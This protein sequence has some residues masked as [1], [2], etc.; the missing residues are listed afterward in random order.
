MADTILDGDFTIFYDEDSN[1]KQLKWTGA[2]AGFRT[3]NELY[4]ALFK[5]F[6][7]P[8]QMEDAMP[9]R[10]DTPTVYR[11]INAYFIDDVTVEHLRGGSIYSSG[12]KSGTTEHVLVIGADQATAFS[13]HDIGHKILGGTTGDTG[14]LLDFNFARKLI[15]IR[16]D[17]PLVGGDEFDNSTEAYTVQNASCAQVWQ[18]D[19]SAGPLF[20]DETTDANSG[21]DNDVTLFPGT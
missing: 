13:V 5:L 10:A 20:T 14:V 4:S 8:S 21:T 9:L 2:D 15:W 18:V 11:L 3:M 1:R 7:D 12:W 6:D 19:A 17:D 16:P